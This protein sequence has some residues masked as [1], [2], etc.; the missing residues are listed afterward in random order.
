[1]NKAKGQEGFTLVEMLI[2]V[3][4][5]AILVAVSIPM[6]NSSLKR[7]R[8]ATDAANERAAKAA[9]VT[10]YLTD[11]EYAPGKK[12]I[13][14]DDTSVPGPVRKYYVYDAENGKLLDT[15]GMGL[16]TVLPQYGKCDKHKDR[17][18]VL[19]IDKSGEVE[20]LWTSGF[21]MTKPSYG[22]VGLCG[23]ALNG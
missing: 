2:V 17:C 1:M 21:P 15:N 19:W 14:A 20:M 6:V 12:V 16:S 5:I 3:A 10:C 7:V 4:I 11:S 8:Q 23:N 18:L 13:A 22:N 9:I